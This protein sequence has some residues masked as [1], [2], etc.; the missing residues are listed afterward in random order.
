MKK[1]LLYF[2]LFGLIFIFVFR[3]LLV[4]FKTDLILNGDYLF[5]IWQ[6]YRNINK[7]LKLDFANFFETNAFY[8]NKLTLLFFRY[9]ATT[10]NYR[11]AYKCNY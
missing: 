2:L 8:P 9:F 5:I 6:M 4:N 1:F 7:I 3:N 11:P 10:I